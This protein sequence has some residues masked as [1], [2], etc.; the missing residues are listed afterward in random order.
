MIVS[1]FNKRSHNNHAS[2]KHCYSIQYLLNIC[3]TKY[4]VLFDSDTVL[5]KDID[6]I[7]DNTVTAADI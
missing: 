7:D 1:F 2:A 6:F 4:M 5:H 3:K